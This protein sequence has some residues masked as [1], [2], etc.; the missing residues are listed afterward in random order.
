MLFRSQLTA[1]Q[2]LIL[3]EGNY[4]L[5]DQPPWDSF[6]SQFDLTIFLNAP[7]DL[8]LQALRDRHL[9][10]GKDLAAVEKHMQFSDTPNMDLILH[11]SKPASVRI[12]KS[13]ARH[14]LRI[15]YPPE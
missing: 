3:I 11:H 6:E 14:I 10:G 5:L 12:E 2:R 9:R 1:Q 7:R 13:D 15:C 8:L 4:L